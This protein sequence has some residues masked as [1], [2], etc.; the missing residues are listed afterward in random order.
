MEIKQLGGDKINQDAIN[1]IRP[2]DLT[3]LKSMNN[4]P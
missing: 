3:E 1:G 2:L 4:P